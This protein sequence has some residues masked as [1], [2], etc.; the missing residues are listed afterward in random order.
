MA[1][2]L[3]KLADDIQVEHQCCRTCFW[4]Q[5]NY[6]GYECYVNPPIAAYDSKERRWEYTRPHVNGYDTACS[7]WKKA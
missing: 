1:G 2:E 7:H 6:D 4:C 5:N 3:L